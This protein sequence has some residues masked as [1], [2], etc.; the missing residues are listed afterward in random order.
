M[1]TT[2]RRAKVTV[3]VQIDKEIMKVI[4]G[5]TDKDMNNFQRTQPGNI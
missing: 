3:L 4:H 5:Y 1:W 2:V